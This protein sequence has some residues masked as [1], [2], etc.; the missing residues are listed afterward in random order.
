MGSAT[1]ILNTW[2][3]GWV[4]NCCR[5]R[6]VPGVLS[7]W[8]RACESGVAPLD[9]GVLEEMVDVAE[10]ILRDCRHG[11]EQVDDEGDV[12]GVGIGCI[13]GECVR[14]VDQRAH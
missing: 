3:G 1:C 5:S 7:G 2:C 8:C 6:N 12:W 13:V 10:R 4:W 14:G 11:F 9:A